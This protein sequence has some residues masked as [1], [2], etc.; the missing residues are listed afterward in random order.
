MSEAVVRLQHRSGERK[1]RKRARMKYLFQRLGAERFIAEV[2][3][4]YDQIEAQ[5]GDAMR[6]E[7]AAMLGSVRAT[8]PTHPGAPAPQTGDAAFAH[9]LRTNT[10]E[11]RQA[12]YFGATIQLP[13]GDVSSSQ[14]RVIADLAEECG[15]GAIRTAND[16]NL[17]IPW[18][19]GDRL[20]KLY[21]RLCEIQL[22]AAD[23]LHITDVVSCSGAD[24]CSLA[25]SR[26]MG[27][28]T[29][30]RDHLL[31]GNGQVEDLGVFRIRISGC[32]NSCGQHQVGD[33]GFTGLSLK[34]DDGNFHPHYSM[35]IGAAVGEDANFGGRI[36]GRFPATEV[37]KVVAA[38]ADHYRAHR[39]SGEHFNAFVR[40]VGADQVSEVARGASASVV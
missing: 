15:A 16:Q 6:A 19:P 34:G 27:L 9:W 12:G 24:Y 37:P 1:N 38:V 2:N 23:A 17:M 13:L 3:A 8:Q 14:I 22:G 11:Q 31:A 20:E 25:M 4:I 36:G 7:L 40:R 30:I 28:A 5:H 21:R 33:L 29:A 18:I 32:P 35:L 26:S 39:Q 10:Y